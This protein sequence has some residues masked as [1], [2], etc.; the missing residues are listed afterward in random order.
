M[1]RQHIKVR[2]SYESGDDT[3]P[4]LKD[5]ISEAPDPEKSK[6]LK[7][8]DTNCILCCPGV[9]YDEITP[10]RVIKAYNEE[11]DRSCEETEPV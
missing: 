5:L 11:G 7:Y 4:P 10:G 3:L 9:F 6:I 8:L 1:M 2:Y